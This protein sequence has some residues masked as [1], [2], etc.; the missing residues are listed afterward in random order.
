MTETSVQSSQATEFQNLREKNC[1]PSVL[2]LKIVPAPETAPR[3]P[4]PLPLVRIF[5]GPL[6]AATKKEKTKTF[7]NRLELLSQ[8]EYLF[9]KRLTGFMDEHRRYTHHF[10]NPFTDQGLLP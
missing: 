9:G 6:S 7:E 10:K 1:V 4:Y 8:T 5:K 3:A 2:L